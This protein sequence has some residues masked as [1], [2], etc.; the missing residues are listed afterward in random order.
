M[1]TR[2]TVLGPV[3]AAIDGEVRG[4]GSPMQR[5]LL[6]YL[7]LESGH[8]VP[9]DALVDALWS[10]APERA[11]N[12]IQQYV[13]GLR[14]AVG[15]DVIETRDAGYRIGEA[16]EVDATSFHQIAGRAERKHHAG[17]LTAAQR[18]DDEA[19]AVWSGTALQ[20]LPDCPFV[21]LVRQQLETE[22][23]RVRLRRYSALVTLGRA[24]D[25]LDNL[26]ELCRQAPLDES[27]AAVL[28][29]ALSSVGRQ[30][31]AFAV[32]E[33]LRTRLADD[34]GV[35]PGPEIRSAHEAVLTQRTTLSAAGGE[36]D[37]LSVTVPDDLRRV[38]GRDADLDLIASAL[39]RHEVSL[40]VLTGFG[41]VGKT[42]LATA[43]ASRLK[44]TRPVLFDPLSRGRATADRRPDDRRRAGR[45]GRRRPAT[46]PADRGGAALS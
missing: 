32:F 21:E 15:R 23:A 40:L 45:A 10:Q 9:R 46:A 13:A 44:Q 1:V 30:A 6:A 4:C 31:D 28:M 25:I 17:E 8:V 14:R 26:H 19:L 27:A 7:C 16:I 20:G 39:A 33:E 18:L 29:R 5:A 12:A 2:V 11:G 3:E 35:D 37:T 24:A 42:R 34:L 41:G 38:I 22:R 36:L 43:V